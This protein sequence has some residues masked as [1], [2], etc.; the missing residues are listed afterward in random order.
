MKL[1]TTQIK[2]ID[3][4][5]GKLKTYSGQHV[6]GLSFEDAEMYCQQNGLGYCKVTGE[7]IT[8]V[9]DIDKELLN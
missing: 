6:P 8:E 2:A 7:L 1:F 9:Y 3:P 4:R 5:D